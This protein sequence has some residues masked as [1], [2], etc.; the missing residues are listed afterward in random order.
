VYDPA[1]GTCNTSTYRCEG[2]PSDSTASG[3]DPCTEDAQCEPGGRCLDEDPDSGAWAGGSCTKFRCDITGNECANDGVCQ[4]AGVGTPACFQ[5][6]TVGGYE[7]T[8]AT[9]TWVAEGSARSTCRAGYGCFWNGVGDEGVADNGVCLPLDYEP[10]ITAPNVGSTCTEDSDCYSPFGNG[11][12][13]QSSAFPNGYCSVRNCG[14]PWFTGLTTPGDNPV[15]GGGGLCV[16]F[17]E[18]D[19]TFALCLQ[20]CT[21]ADECTA[22]LG[23][24]DIDMSGTRACFPCDVDADCRAGERCNTTTDR[25]VP[26]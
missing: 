7:T 21:A 19:P 10:A 6:C 15:C 3:G 22:G 25:C 13:L 9:S 2:G 17:D 20:R 8:S 1:A 23:C 12:C 11:V 18:M 16:G 24:V 26:A 14:A 4:E 5:G